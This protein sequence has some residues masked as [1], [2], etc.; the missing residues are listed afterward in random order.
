MMQQYCADRMIEIIK[1]FVTRD[2]RGRWF[3]N[4]WD[5]VNTDYILQDDVER[6]CPP[7]VGLIRFL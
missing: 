4:I 7:I 2:E 6:Y 5:K 3:M 1:R